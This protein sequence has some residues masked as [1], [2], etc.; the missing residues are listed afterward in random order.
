VFDDP[1]DLRKVIVQKNR[2]LNKSREVAGYCW[3]WA[4]KKDPA[5]MDI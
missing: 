5:A 4:S 1:E 3:D 2:V